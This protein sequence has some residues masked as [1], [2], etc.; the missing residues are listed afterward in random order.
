VL[1]R[2][3]L[4]ARDDRR[5]RR[6]TDLAPLEQL[7]GRQLLA[8]TSLGYS[9]PNLRVFAQAGPVASWG[10]TLNVTAFLQNT[11][12]STINEPL[13]LIPPSQVLPGPDGLPV[14]PYA[15]P[16]SADVPANEVDI[17]LA[18]RRNSLVGAINLGP[19]AAPSSTTLVS[20]NDVTT[21]GSTVTLPSRP[22]GFPASGRF[23]IRLVANVNNEVVAPVGSTTVS[24]A[25][26]VRFVARAL[27]ELRVTALDLPSTMQPGDTVV[28][29]IQITNLGTAPAPAGTQVALV[30]SVTPTFTL[31]SSIVALYTL[32]SAIPAQSSATLS[33]RGKHGNFLS[34]G[35]SQQNVNPGTNVLTYTGAAATLPVSPSRYYV[36]VVIDPNGQLTQLSLPSNRLEQVRIVGPSNGLPTA[37]VISTTPPQSF[38]NPPDGVPIGLSNTNTSTGG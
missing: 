22:A 13:S 21:V 31:G 27:P 32:P 4:R 20:Q 3:N 34:R 26:P 1:S 14:P 38:P 17:Y 15:I 33:L 36:G 19:I 7:E 37:G 2:E 11:G 29:T 25:V 12:A 10:G 8:Y 5:A 30:A 16:S 18:P 9:L 24:P 35:I 6:R 23:Y 28:P